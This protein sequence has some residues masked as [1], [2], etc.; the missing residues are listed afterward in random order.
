[1]KN[2]SYK[3]KLLIIILE[4][5]IL[6][7]LSCYRIYEFINDNKEEVKE[8][9]NN[10]QDGK[11]NI[12]TE[13]Q[14]NDKIKILVYQINIRKEANENSEDIGD[15]LLNEVYDVLEIVDT[16]N[17]NWYKI[18][19]NG[20]IGYVAN[21]KGEKWLEYSENGQFEV[22][23]EYK[24]V[25]EDC[26]IHD[27]T[28]SVA[29]VY[30][31]NK[32][33]I[34]DYKTKEKKY[35]NIVDN[36][37]CSMSLITYENKFYGVSCSSGN[38]NNVFYYSLGQNKIIYDISNF[39]DDNVYEWSFD[40]ELDLPFIRVI[41][42]W[43][44]EKKSPV[45]AGSIYFDNHQMIIFEIRN[46]KIILSVDDVAY[47]RDEKIGDTQYYIIPYI[48][49][50][51]DSNYK[52]IDNIKFEPYRGIGCYEAVLWNHSSCSQFNYLINNNNSLTVINDN[53]YIIYDKNMKEIYTSIEYEQIYLIKDYVITIKEQK[54]YIFD[55]NG[56]LIKEFELKEKDSKITG[57]LHDKNNVET[58]KIAIGDNYY[59]Y[60][61][62][63]G[64][65]GIKEVEY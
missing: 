29:F 9:E 31:D 3:V 30:E 52:L 6:I 7:G 65:S 35:L 11:D 43:N 55:L 23:N 64:E 8:N 50:I 46:E 56:K 39:I 12:S 27:T 32:Y 45:T 62:S 53:K 17:Y 22:V 13:E 10:D 20:I 5:I 14:T 49:S 15:V 48:G 41:K 63:T 36:V 2:K 42:H 40:I 4:S 26:Q 33:F 18:N 19:K 25:S 59:Y 61:P 37:H 51:Y 34:Y 21:Q 1:M 24:C 57:V 28:D 16:T 58:F 60:I 54:M 38:Y 47:L 44:T